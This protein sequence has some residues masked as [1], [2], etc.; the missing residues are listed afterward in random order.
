M[1]FF[2]KD[3]SKRVAAERGESSE[4]SP[5]EII[6]INVPRWGEEEGYLAARNGGA[7]PSAGG[8]RPPTLHFFFSFFVFSYILIDKMC[9]ESEHAPEALVAA[10]RSDSSL[11]FGC[12]DRELC[13]AI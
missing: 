13:T 5:R 9:F 4:N 1:N 10:I 3:I 7:P 12:T 2:K 8:C 6:V 11:Q